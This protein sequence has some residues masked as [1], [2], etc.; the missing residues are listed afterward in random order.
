M[1][2]F[3]RSEPVDE[4]TA[5]LRH[6]EVMRRLSITR[7]LQADDFSDE[8]VRLRLN[9]VDIG[10]HGFSSIRQT[11]FG[12]ERVHGALVLRIELC[13]LIDQSDLAVFAPA[14]P[15]WSTTSRMAIARSCTLPR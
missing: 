5:G 1:K 4:E 15:Q 13:K 6:Q 8:R 3:D 12:D 11:D 9:R 2:R 7:P 10:E 14:H